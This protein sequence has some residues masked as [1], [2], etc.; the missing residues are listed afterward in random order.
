MLPIWREDCDRGEG[1]PGIKE[2]RALLTLPPTGRQAHLRSL[3][4]SRG[5][6][7]EGGTDGSGL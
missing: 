5:L 1:C 2:V 6:E 4:P 7:S 3:S